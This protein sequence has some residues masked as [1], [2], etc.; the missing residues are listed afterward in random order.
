[1]SRTLEARDVSFAYETG[2]NVFTRISAAIR[3]GRI[4][5]VVGP[6]GSG[7]STLLRV[8][9]GILRA[10]EGHVSLDGE[11]L[12]TLSHRARARNVALLPQSVQPAFALTVLEVVSL[13]RYPHAG[14]LGGLSQ[15]DRDIVHRCLADVDVVG[16]RDREFLTLSGGERQ[17]VLLA[18]VL[19]QEPGLLLLDEPTSS[20]DIHHEI[21]IYALLRRLAG[22]GYGMA[23]VTHDLNL[24]ARFCDDLLLMSLDGGGL[25]ASGTPREVLTESLL[26]TAY[27]GTIRVSENPLTKTPLITAIEAEEES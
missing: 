6:N 11:A 18:S 19:A 16:L 25:L 20:L 13:G 17:R 1:M 5:G 3:G 4:T 10:R 22:E 2:D 14:L 21:E 15:R 24:A 12:S 27:S 8:L 7:K 9:A 23:V 26:M